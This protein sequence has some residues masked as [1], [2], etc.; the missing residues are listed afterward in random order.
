[1]GDLILQKILAHTFTKADFYRGI[2]ALQEALEHSFFSGDG[3]GNASEVVTYLF[4]KQ[5]PSASRVEKWGDAVVS[6]FNRDN[7]YDRIGDLK[8]KV[9]ELP[10]LVLYVPV[11]LEDH[12]IES[13][14]GWFRDSVNPN[15]ILDVIVDTDALGGCMFAWKGVFY[16]FSLNHFLKEKR[17]DIRALINAYHV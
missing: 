7:L 14:G 10:T 5:D 9:E 6:A 15:A 11:A 3:Q 17:G 16:D 12:E 2:D 4:A 8:T 1:M 13:I